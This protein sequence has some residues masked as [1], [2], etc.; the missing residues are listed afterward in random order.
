MSRKL[1]R[2][3]MIFALILILGFVAGAYVAEV[4]F[5]FSN[6]QILKVLIPLSLLTTFVERFLNKNKKIGK[7]LFLNEQERKRYLG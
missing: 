6:S 1:S 3:E 5:G 4:Y 2:N 7:K